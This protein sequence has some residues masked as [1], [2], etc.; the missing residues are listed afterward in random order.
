MVSPV[1]KKQLVL[2]GSL[3]PWVCFGVKRMA[4]KYETRHI[5]WV[6]NVKAL[7]STKK[8]RS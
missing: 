4:L 6:K 3:C 2:H 7:L 5:N 1:K 8:L